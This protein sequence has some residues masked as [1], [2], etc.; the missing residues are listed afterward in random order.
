MPEPLR[1]LDA[2]LSRVA[3]RW[4]AA[5]TERTLEALHVKKQRRMLRRRAAW[6]GAA[7]A[8][9]ALTFGLWTRPWDGTDSQAGA[10]HEFS[11]QIRLADG[12]Q[13]WLRDAASRVRVAQDAPQRVALE[14]EAG[15][16][17]FDV[18]HVEGRVFRVEAGLVTVEVLG[19]RFHV[20]R[21]ADRTRVEVSRGRVAVSWPE[22]RVELAAGEAGWFPRTEPEPVAAQQ[23]ALPSPTTPARSAR[24]SEPGRKA[25][26]HGAS[27]ASVDRSPPLA[28]SSAAQR[29]DAAAPSARGSTQ[30]AESTARAAPPAKAWREAAEQGEFEHAYKLLERTSNPV[31]DDVEELLLAADSARLSGHPEAALPFLRKVIERH[32]SDSRA[33]LAAFTLGGVLMQQLGQPREAEAAYARARELSLNASLAEDALARQVEA[34][35]RAGDA[36]RARSLAREY[37]ERYPSGRRQH[38]VQRFGGLRE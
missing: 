31:A 12:S 32:T 18:T 23:V 22:G 21:E 26:P 27:R 19:T 17:R 3:D 34:A 11:R 5:R 9:A 25:T 38:A 14:L 16:A 13:V 33:P 4:N 1:D 15:A 37:M 29:S 36:A 7:I 30:A 2:A 10:A 8:V 24:A 35:H 28:A 20:E 6:G